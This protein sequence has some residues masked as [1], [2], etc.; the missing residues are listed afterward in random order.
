MGEQII[1]ISNNYLLEWALSQQTVLTA[2][3]NPVSCRV[4]W[5]TAAKPPRKASWSRVIF[6]LRLM[7]YLFARLANSSSIG[8]GSVIEIFSPGIVL[9]WSDWRRL[10]QRFFR[11]S[12]RSNVEKSRWPG[13]RW[14]FDQQMHTYIENKSD[15]GWYKYSD[16]VKR[17]LYVATPVVCTVNTWCKV[18]P[19][20]VDEKVHK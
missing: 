8:L 6:P 2:T 7:Q 3:W 19:G 15:F 5:Y 12:R 20:S 11:R 10:F 14:R 18:Q 17:H 16:G 13:P 1:N 4:P 9:Q